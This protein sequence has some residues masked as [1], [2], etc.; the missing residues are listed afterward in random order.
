MEGM[1][2]PLWYPQRYTLNWNLEDIAHRTHDGFCMHQVVLVYMALF[3]QASIEL[4]LRFGAECSTDK[5]T[6]APCI[7]GMRFRGS[8]SVLDSR[9]Q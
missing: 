8:L 1:V 7:Y 4:G 9:N 3:C 6:A 2:L 5:T